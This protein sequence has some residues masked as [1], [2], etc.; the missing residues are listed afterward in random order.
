MVTPE[1][2]ARPAAELE[3]MLAD[4]EAPARRERFLQASQREREL[5]KESIWRREQELLQ[6]YRLPLTAA[7]VDLIADQYLRCDCDLKTAF[8]EVG[9]GYEQV[10]GFAARFFDDHQ[11]HLEFDAEAMDEILRQALEGGV[12]A[13]DICQDL[14]QDLEYALKLVR[15]RTS[16]DEFLLT[17][18]AISNLDSYL[19]RVIRDYYQK[20]L[21]REGETIR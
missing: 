2:V 1:I 11:I 6:R 4:P 14:A 21:F 5:L 16:Q 17:R 15:D 9:R 20:T 18:E 8:E 7:R 10:Q 3:E 19:N 12:A 13:A